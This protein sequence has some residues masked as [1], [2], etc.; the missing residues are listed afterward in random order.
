MRVTGKWREY[1]NVPSPIRPEESV[2]CEKDGVGLCKQGNY[3]FGHCRD[4]T[5]QVSD[6]EGSGIQPMFR[7]LSFWLCFKASAM[8]NAPRVLILFPAPKEELWA[9]G[10]KWIAA[11]VHSGCRGGRRQIRRLVES[12]NTV[13]QGNKQHHLK[14]AVLRAPSL[15]MP[16]LHC[17]MIIFHRYIRGNIYT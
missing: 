3:K 7:F 4:P 17:K 12:Y 16:V 10:R 9:V 11:R 15:A 13:A 6:R 5:G 1:Q 8:A 14:A 2:C